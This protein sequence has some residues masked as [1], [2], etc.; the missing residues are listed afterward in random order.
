MTQT[1]QTEVQGDD[2][3]SRCRSQLCELLRLLFEFGEEG[4]S[5][6]SG[7]ACTSSAEE[8]VHVVR[9]EHGFCLLQGENHRLL[10]DVTAG[11]EKEEQSWFCVQ[12]VVVLSSK[13]ANMK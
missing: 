11:L 3:V 10:L 7:H 8:A 4:V 1:L 5:R 2:R 12:R 6:L 9:L 13:S